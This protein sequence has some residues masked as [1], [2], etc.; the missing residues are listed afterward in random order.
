MLFRAYRIEEATGVYRVK[1]LPDGYPRMERP[2]RG[3]Q[4]GDLD[5]EPDAN[6]WHG[7]RVRLLSVLVPEGEL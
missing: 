2:R 1:L 5:E 7:L 6:W 3:R 4:R